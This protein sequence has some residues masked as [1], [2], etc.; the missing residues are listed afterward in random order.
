MKSAFFTHRDKAVEKSEELQRRFNVLS[1]KELPKPERLR[2]LL[3]DL[4][5]VLS[6]INEALISIG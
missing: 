3:L 4:N 2:D 1:K 6:E 5:E